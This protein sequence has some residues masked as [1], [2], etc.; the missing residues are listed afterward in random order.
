MVKGGARVVPVS[1]S[2]VP[3]VAQRKKGVLQ[4]VKGGGGGIF[5]PEEG[6]LLTNTASAAYLAAGGLG[7]E[8]DAKMANSVCKEKD[9]KKNPAVL[10]FSA[11]AVPWFFIARKVGITDRKE[12]HRGMFFDKC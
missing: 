2:A 5:D 4:P 1:D 7:S 12:I 8:M 9:C 3:A 6:V 11:L 10:F